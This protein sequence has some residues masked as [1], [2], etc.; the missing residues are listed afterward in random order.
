MTYDVHF[1]AASSGQPPLMNVRDDRGIPVTELELPPSMSGP[2]EVDDELRK[3][4]W[5]RTAD[6]TTS[7]DGWIAQVEPGD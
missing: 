4:G 7:D 5:L 2:Q 6:W 3:A 1:I